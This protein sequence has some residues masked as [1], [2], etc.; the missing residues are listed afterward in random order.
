MLFKRFSNEIKN[1]VVL[2][3]LVL[4]SVIYAFQSSAL[5]YYTTVNQ[6]QFSVKSNSYLNTLV[7]VAGSAV[8]FLL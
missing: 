6:Q 8:L 3:S 4:F 2:L 1:T 5:H 7:V